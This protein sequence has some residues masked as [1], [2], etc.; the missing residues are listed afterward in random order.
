MNTVAFNAQTRGESS[1]RVNVSEKIAQDFVWIDVFREDIVRDPVAWQNDMQ[2]QLGFRIDDFHITDILNTQHPSYFDQTH[3]YEFLIFRKL[4]S[5]HNDTETLDPAELTTAPVAFIITPT[6]LITV[7]ESDSQTFAAVR[8]RLEQHLKSPNNARLPISSLDL[9]LRILNALVDKY[10]DLRMPLT[11]RIDLW[12]NLL[13]QGN[14][15][16][17]NWQQLLNERL[18]LHQ[19]DSLCEEQLDS[20]QELRDEY[21]D[22]EST[23]AAHGTL[24]RRDVMMVR[25]NDLMEHVN[26]VQSH[27]SRLENALK[28][29]VELHF[30]ATAHQ[31]NENLRFLAILSAVFAPLTLLT[32]IYGMNFDVIPGLHNQNG[33]WWMM[34][35]MFAV[36]AVLLYY[37]R[38]RR[39]VGRGDASIAALLNDS[40]RTPKT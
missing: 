20:L 37:F 6:V 7:R 22:K 9:M 1:E 30:S 40:S 25:I 36:T 16:F 31:T 28:S 21:L 11:R 26:R 15:R 12:Q 4:L 38:Y 8:Q 34:G 29:A 24:P 19:L 27:A 39:L 35:S 13:L 32:G 18:A 5:K 10:L 17:N 14:H 23:T 2:A 3:D 33:F